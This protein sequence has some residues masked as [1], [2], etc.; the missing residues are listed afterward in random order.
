MILIFKRLES[1][2]TYNESV[3][4]I[5]HYII[6]HKNE[7]LSYYMKRFPEISLK[8]QNDLEN[9]KNKQDNHTNISH[10]HKPNVNFDEYH[11]KIS[12]KTQYFN[13]LFKTLKPKNQVNQFRSE[14]K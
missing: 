5:Y 3:K 4:E 1:P 2:D 9:M 12:T 14:Y 10:T 13:D 6:E 7:D 11:A 8:L